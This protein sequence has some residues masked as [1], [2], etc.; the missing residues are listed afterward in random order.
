[1]QFLVLSLNICYLSLRFFYLS[2]GGVHG[3]VES[4]LMLCTGVLGMGHKCCLYQENYQQ[5]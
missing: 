3:L 4:A 1:M 5:T 2:G